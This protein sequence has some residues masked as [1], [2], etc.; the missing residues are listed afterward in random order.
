MNCTEF[1]STRRRACLSTPFASAAVALCSMLSAC[2]D[3]PRCPPLPGGA[4]YCLQSS[5]AVQAFTALQDIHLQGRG[6]DERLIAR[7]EV[8]HDGMRLAGLTPMG[9]RVLEARF[10]N[11]AATADSLAGSGIDA[12]ALLSLVQ[13]ATWPVDTVRAG[14]RDGWTLE[15]T[16]TRRRILHN[17]QV[18]MEI[19]GIGSPPHYA[20]LTIFLPRIELMLTVTEIVE[21][22][23]DVR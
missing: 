9:Q 6:L 18:F 16:S 3:D 8:D 2:T 22:G 4:A 11:Q 10:D 12:R 7:L 17:D 5:G 23:A 13:L 15:E 14:L 1:M 21:E 19:A 20:N